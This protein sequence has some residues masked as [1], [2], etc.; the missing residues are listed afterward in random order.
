MS[1][2]LL[3]ALLLAA[4]PT[5]P[6]DLLN[7][8]R[9]AN[10]YQTAATQRSCADASLEPRVAATRQRLARIRRGM[11]ATYGEEILRANEVA[12]VF[13]GDLC[14]DPRAAANS[15][16]NFDLAVADLEAAVARAWRR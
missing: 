3:L 8:Y 13:A 4:Q 14:A 5:A 11:I 9:T 7:L 15:A 12:V 6:D 1:G 2:G 16:A 10:A